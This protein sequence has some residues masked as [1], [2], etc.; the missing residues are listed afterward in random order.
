MK[1]LLIFFSIA[2]MGCGVGSFEN[3]TTTPTMRVD[4][5]SSV[6]FFT[7]HSD[8]TVATTGSKYQACRFEHAGNPDADRLCRCQEWGVMP[9]SFPGAYVPSMGY[10]YPAG[11][12][13][14]QAYCGTPTYIRTVP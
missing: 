9:G 1:L 11:F 13:G 2:S 4:S 14:Y 10:W 12:M 8:T 5:S 3:R 6:G 7:S